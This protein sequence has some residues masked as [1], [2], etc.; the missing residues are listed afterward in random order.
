MPRCGQKPFHSRCRPKG[1]IRSNIWIHRRAA[2]CSIH[3]LRILV[4]RFQHFWL[5]GR[6]S[7]TGRKTYP[8]RF[9]CHADVCVSQHLHRW[10]LAS[11]ITA[12]AELSVLW[13]RECWGASRSVCGWTSAEMSRLEV[14]G[15]T[16]S[17]RR[18]WDVWGASAGSTTSSGRRGWDVW[19]ASARSKTSSGR[20]GWDVWGASARSKTSSGRR[21]WDVWG[22]PAGS[23][24]TRWGCTIQLGQQRASTLVPS[25]MHPFQ[26][27]QLWHGKWV[28]ILP[29]WR[30]SHFQK[31]GQAWEAKSTRD[32]RLRALIHIILLPFLQ[33]SEME[34]H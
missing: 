18:G 3:S 2:M 28:R 4:A 10:I 20:R 31:F 32:G 17:G 12:L 21:G 9:R 25:A 6:Y 13:R 5:Q 22:W 1:S 14:S 16:S 8:L 27:G 23:T 19:G 7:R 29:F 15:K 26:Q 24:A 33:Q 34:V 11:L 30:A